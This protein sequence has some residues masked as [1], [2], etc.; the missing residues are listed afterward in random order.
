MTPPFSALW[1]IRLWIVAGN[2]IT[3]ALFLWIGL[4]IDHRFNSAPK[5]LIISLIVS[6]PLAQ[7]VTLR[8]LK[9]FLRPRQP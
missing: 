5:G 7:V 1:S 6:F 8:L 4:S 3:I 2:L 9:P